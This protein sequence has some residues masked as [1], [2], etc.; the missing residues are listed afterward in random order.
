MKEGGYKIYLIKCPNSVGPKVPKQGEGQIYLG[1]CLK[2][3]GFHSGRHPNEIQLDDEDE[4]LYI[5]Y[6]NQ[7]RQLKLLL[8]ELMG[9]VILKIFRIQMYVS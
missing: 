5:T 9:R 8:N 7:T 1:R 6:N 4:I 3:L 2:F